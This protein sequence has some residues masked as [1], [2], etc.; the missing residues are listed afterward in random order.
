VGFGVDG[1]GGNGTGNGDGRCWSIVV[2]MTIF[3]PISEGTFVDADCSSHGTERPAITPRER[4]A[5]CPS[6]A[7]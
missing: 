5:G 3:L 6:S 4:T 2:N 7:F 1:G